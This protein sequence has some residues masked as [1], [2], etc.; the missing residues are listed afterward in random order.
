MMRGWREL[1][2]VDD[3]P[4]LWFELTGILRDRQALDALDSLGQEQAV[5]LNVVIPGRLPLDGLMLLQERQDDFARRVNSEKV[6]LNALNALAP[7]VA[8]QRA[9]ILL[10]AYQMHRRA[11]VAEDR[12]QLERKGVRM[13]TDNYTERTAEFAKWLREMASSAVLTQAFTNRNDPLAVSPTLLQGVGHE[14]EPFLKR[15]HEG[16]HSP[17]LFGVSERDDARVGEIAAVR[18]FSVIVQGIGAT[19]S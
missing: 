6:A 5:T 3:Y 19:M 10:P 16:P 17:A 1:S 7:A 4:R 11:H 8:R 14:L 12:T 15:L 9:L 18:A 2:L 13:A